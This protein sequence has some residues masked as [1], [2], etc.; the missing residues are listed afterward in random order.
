[1]MCGGI[2]EHVCKSDLMF[3]PDVRARNLL[4]ARQSHDANPAAWE[5][6]G[7][8]RRGGIH[9][10]LGQNAVR[11]GRHEQPNSISEDYCLFING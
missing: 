1:M 5:A 9:K 8:G 2:G 3:R 7:S 6:G 11:R 4:A 10:R